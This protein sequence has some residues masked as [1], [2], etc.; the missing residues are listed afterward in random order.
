[1]FHV[2]TEW[3]LIKLIH[4]QADA[5]GTEGPECPDS[6]LTFYNLVL[7]AVY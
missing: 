5:T 6:C 7:S 4:T 2:C 3:H 1:M